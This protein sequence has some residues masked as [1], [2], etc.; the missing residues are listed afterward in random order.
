MTI[1]TVHEP[2]SRFKEAQRGTERFRFVRDGF[3]F[4][5]FLTPLLWLLWHRL[6]LVLL[7]YL[8]LIAGLAFALVTFKVSTG[9]SVLIYLMLALLVGLEAGTL[10]RWT[11]GRN[12][13]R[14]LGVVSGDD[15]EAAERR[16][17]STWTPDEMSS[18]AAA[19]TASFFGWRSQ[20][21]NAQT[22]VV[23][24]FPEPSSR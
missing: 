5:A 10:R 6:W 20:P 15:V 11:L 4:W 23:G 2:P 3:Y 12:K 7:G 18:H 9:P 22:D 13:W 21:V 16:F 14:D 1:Y 17:F 8:V 24:L 19:P